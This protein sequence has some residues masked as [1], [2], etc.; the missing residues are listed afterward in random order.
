MTSISSTRLFF[1]RYK[2][3]YC[4][5][6]PQSSSIVVIEGRKESGGGREEN[7]S[8]PKSVNE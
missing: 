2:E 1:P 7:I 6:Y 8:P 5:L 4:I 3:Q